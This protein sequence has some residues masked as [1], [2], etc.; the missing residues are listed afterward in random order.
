[1]LLAWCHRLCCGMVY[2][3]VGEYVVVMS[4]AGSSRAII[5]S[6]L[7]T[8]SGR[9]GKRLATLCSIRCWRRNSSFRAVD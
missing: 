9:T 5:V 8:S 6:R 2:D 3:K 7:V 1:M 4:Q